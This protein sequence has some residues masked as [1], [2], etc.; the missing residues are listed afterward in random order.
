MGATT[1]LSGYFIKG[2]G[3]W[4]IK[5]GDSRLIPC[6]AEHKADIVEDSM[7]IGVFSPVREDYLPKEIDNK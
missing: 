4:K 5:T 6:G 3:I 7:A 2:F 1:C